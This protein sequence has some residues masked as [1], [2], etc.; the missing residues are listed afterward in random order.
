MVIEI[1]SDVVCPFCYIGKRRIENAL[2]KFEHKEDIELV[3]HS[4]QLYPEMKTQ[5]DKTLYEYMAERDEI[6]VED[7]KLEY[8]FIDEMAK[9]VGLDYH[10]DKALLVNTKNAHLLIQM[11]KKEGKD[12][13]AEELLFQAYFIENKN[14]D[15]LDTLEKI[16]KNIGI[17]KS[18][19]KKIISSDIFSEE[20]EKDIYQSKQIGVRG[21]PFFL[22]NNELSINGA[23]E[24]QVFLN[25]I[26]KSWNTWHLNGQIKH[27]IIEG[28]TCSAEGNCNV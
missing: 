28:K 7:V 27:S 16:A 20:F 18:N 5:P 17:D 6:T 15:D 9:E 21:V 2:S 4:Y 22:M 13:K 14:I 25:A 23:Q 1:W 10:L 19:F 8:D 11:A 24:E 3:W 12:S 26:E